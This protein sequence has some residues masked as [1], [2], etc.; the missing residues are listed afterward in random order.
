MILPYMYIRIIIV[1]GHRGGLCSYISWVTVPTNSIVHYESLTSYEL[2]CIAM[3]QT[4][5][6]RNY[7]PTNQQNL[8]N[9]RTLAPENYLKKFWICAQ[10]VMPQVKSPCPM[11]HEIRLPCSSLIYILHL[12]VQ[13]ILVFSSSCKLWPVSK[14]KP[15]KLYMYHHLMTHT[16]LYKFCLIV[17]L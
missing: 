9:P 2:L 8:D 16:C 17:V 13:T 10:Q 4:S 1:H 6:Q 5:Y 14:Y 11:G 12:I 15:N 3:Q 7:F